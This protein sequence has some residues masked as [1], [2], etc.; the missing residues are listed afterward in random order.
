MADPGKY[1]FGIEKCI[2][3][4]IHSKGESTTISP[5][6]E[7]PSKRSDGEGASSECALQDLSISA[8]DAT[9][10]GEIDI[11]TFDHVSL[12]ATS[13]SGHLRGYHPEDGRKPIKGR[14]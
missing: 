14:R 6:G 10:T 13:P 1:V 9:S 12:E 5:D 2:F 4:I 11:D 8:L 7:S 3:D